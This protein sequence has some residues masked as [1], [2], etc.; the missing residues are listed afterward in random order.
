MDELATE[1]RV[2]IPPKTM[3]LTRTQEDELVEFAVQRLDHYRRGMGW[4][5]SLAY[6]RG[7]WMWK[8]WVATR[9][10]EHNFEH[11]RLQARLFERVNLSLGM[12]AQ[13]IEQHKSRITKDLVAGEA[14]YGVVPDGAEDQDPVLRDVER[15]LQ[16][17]G[18]RMGLQERFRTSG[19]LGAMIRGE[20]VSKTSLKACRRIETRRVRVQLSDGQ[21]VQDTSGHW[22]TNLDK[23]VPHPENPTVKMLERDP[24]VQMAADGVPVY[25]EKE[26]DLR[27]TLN[28]TRGS[29]VEFPHWADLVIPVDAVNMDNAELLAHVFQ[30]A[31]S[32]LIDS[33]PEDGFGPALPRYKQEVLGGGT[34]AVSEPADQAELAEHRGEQERSQPAEYRGAYSERRFD[35]IYLRV[36]WRGN[37]RF[38]R[39][40]ILLDRELRWPIYYGLAGE[41][42]PWTDRPHPFQAWR[43]MPVADRWYGRG[44]YERYGDQSDFAD[45]CWCRM[46]LELQRSGNLIVEN[47]DLHAAGRAGKPIRFR[48]PE[49]IQIDGQARPEDVVSVITV[50]PQTA[51]ID[52]AMQF[53]LQKLQSEGGFL[54]PGDPTTEALNNSDTLG[55]AK[56]QEANKNVSIEERE[57]ELVM[58]MNETLQAMAEIELHPDILDVDEVAKLLEKTGKPAPSL[59]QLAMTEAGIMPAD[60]ARAMQA[61]GPGAPGGPVAGPPL[62]DMAALPL[63]SGRERAERLLEWARQAGEDLRNSIKVFMTKA[64]QTQL[65]DR[66]SKVLQVLEKWLQY[67]AEVR[68]ILRPVFA[69]MLRSLDVQAPDALLGPPDEQ[70]PPATQGT[71]M[72]PGMTVMPS[73]GSREPR[74]A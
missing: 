43:I 13:L 19:I 2:L 55:E 66:S 31:A 48:S 56:I 6:N 72:A 32:D 70:Q 22:V 11:R 57:A 39:I 7:S 35:E 8:R 18:L 69:D 28:E 21:P 47:R 53:T 44:Y 26:T 50:K 36:D 34:L 33:L 1:P 51:E 25:A 67:P 68:T 4:E 29:L 61:G 38:D 65:F 23:W 9:M 49:T 30:M 73:Q 62:P 15:W 54:G 64:R 5:S 59:P 16:R 14:F 63:P 58:G 60:E 40:V 12:V 3:R 71:G 10:F 24:L 37:G 74:A 41:I 46:E 27:V 52:R 45:K 20:A 17:Q 42:M